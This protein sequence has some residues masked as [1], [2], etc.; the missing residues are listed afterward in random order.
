MI[1][2]RLLVETTSELLD[3]KSEAQILAYRAR[4][5]GQGDRVS[6]NRRARVTV[7]A[8][9]APIVATTGATAHQQ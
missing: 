6:A 5:A 7:I 4:C 8:S 9:V 1:G 2:P 3:R